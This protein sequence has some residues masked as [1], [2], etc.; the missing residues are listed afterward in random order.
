MIRHSLGVA[1][2]GLVLFT[3]CSALDPYATSP[4]KSPAGAPPGQRVAI[5]YNGM[6]TALA[7][8]QR[9]AQGECPANTVAEPESTDYYL[10]QCPMLLPARGTFLC[11]ATK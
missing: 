8:V 7:E 9:Q 1:L 5:C 2:L 4:R 11:R 10:M 3:A 6:E